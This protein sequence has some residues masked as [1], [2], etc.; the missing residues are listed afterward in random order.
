VARHG[1]GSPVGAV[2]DF[3]SDWAVLS[4]AIWT[5]IA[6]AGMATSAAA[7]LL[8]AL[9]LVTVPL[10]GA[11]LAIT[12]RRI[13]RIP[14]PARGLPRAAD[15]RMHTGFA[16]ASVVCGLVSAVLV[17][18]GAKVPWPIVWAP[19]GTAV[20]L[21]VAL[22]CLQRAS[23][24][25]GTFGLF[26]LVTDVIAALVS[27]GFAALSLFI[28]NGD[29]DD[30]FYVNRATATAQLNR[31]PVRDVVFTDERVAPISGAGL[32][33]DALHALQGATAR[34]L[35]VHAASMAYLVTTPV[36]TFLAT[37][38]L[39]RLLRSWTPRRAALSF[40]LAAVYWLWSAQLILNPGALFLT[41]LWQGK[42][43]FVAWLIPTLY[44]LL[45]RWLGR[46][47]PATAALLI[48]AG[49]ASIGL[50]ASATFI[51]PLVFAAAALVLLAR[52]QWRALPVVIGSAAI[53]FCV[54][55]AVTSHY[56][57][58]RE[59]AP[60]LRDNQWFFANVFG[61]G[62]V[63]T[64]GAAGIWLAPWAARAGPP[65]N[66]ATGVAVIAAVLLAPGILH[67]L[68]D[69]SG[70]TETLR[71]AL[72]VV[73]IP[74]LV[75]LLA[76]IPSG[77]AP[78]VIATITVAALLVAFGQPLWRS[79]LEGSFWTTSPGWKGIA[80][81]QDTA[82]GILERYHQQGAILAN[83]GVMRAIA[84]QTVH[85][86]AVNARS[87]YARLL[88]EPKWRT[89][90]RLLLTRF[91]EK[92]DTGR[93]GSVMHALNDL[94]VGLVCL[95]ADK[96]RRAHEIGLDAVFRSAFRVNGLRCLQR[97]TITR[98]HR[99]DSG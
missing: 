71:R 63:A 61:T 65:R 26:P 98:Q 6:Y 88:P 32:P 85:P 47:D 78:A 14:H 25:D 77:R 34:L 70:L 69:A 3:G 40:V 48:A 86:K 62:V 44:V 27:S 41:R 66:I 24:A 73:P 82:R 99:R 87:L 4:F 39:W 96:A 67:L 54:G 52:K 38:A 57:L 59:L 76:A 18:L 5:L 81:H 36:A 12:R 58:V 75:G 89:S 92:G 68:S 7:T 93:P 51:A 45:T 8:V 21:A 17:G 43:I 94:R 2:L 31:I 56:P 9:W 83:E 37:W 1:S 16:T 84:I 19:A 90:E 49:I 23:E 55:V 22:G 79:R 28:N 42:V 10:A 53:P 91:A 50:T 30:A 95:D 80:G 20:A 60:G 15:P 13:H 97:R 33:V 35:G 72:W 11:A 64:I 29:G 46:R 74:A